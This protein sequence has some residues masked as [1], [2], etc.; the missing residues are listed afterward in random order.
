MEHPFAHEFVRSWVFMGLWGVPAV[1][2][3]GTALLPP[4]HFLLALFGG[5]LLAAPIFVARWLF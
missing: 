4:P 5:F 3:A 2:Y 1:V